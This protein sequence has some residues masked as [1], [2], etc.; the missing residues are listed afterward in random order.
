MIDLTGYENYKEI[1]DAFLL[2]SSV[3]RG[4]GNTAPVAELLMDYAKQNG[5]YAKRDKHDNVIYVKPATPGYE[6]R[7]TVILQGHT[8]MVAQK[9]PDCTKD[10]EKEGIEVVR[11]GESLIANG[12][13]LGGDD[14]VAIAYI[15]ALFK[16]NDIPHPRIEAIMTSDEEIGLLGA[17]GIGEDLLSE[18][19]GKLLI[20]VDS[21]EEGIFTAG[22]AGGMRSDISLPVVREAYEGECYTVAVK[23]LEG[24]HS[25]IE[26]DKGRL[27][28]SKLLADM[29][30]NIDGVRLVEL[31]GGSAD[32]A[33]PR[34]AVAKILVKGN[35]K[36]KILSLYEKI[37]KENET[38][39]P[40][41]TVTVEKSE[42]N[43]TPLNE[44]YSRRVIELICELPSGVISYFQ[45][46]PELVKTSLNLGIMTL[47]YDKLSL[48]FS[49]RS[50]IGE[51]KR[52]LGDR[53]SEI[54]KKYGAGYSERGGYPAWE[55]RESSYLRDT[56]L[57]LYK[58]TYGKDAEVVV[59]HAGLECGLLSDKIEGLDCVS[60]GPDNKY[61]HTTEERLSIPSFV[62]VWDYLKALLKEI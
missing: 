39:E 44:L 40:N 18:L 11:D 23:G 60:I 52:A 59:I 46:I 4:S 25:G 2:L 21:D 42:C 38:N 16:S 54:S 3:P 19:C 55:Y 61:I 51:E 5:I 45:D 28:A 48:S 33:I 56:M 31:N 36:D 43:A 47:E 20:N 24:G 62:R 49:V 53:L 22:C 29:L 17:D 34:E 58:D 6:D 57:K 30:V 12:T 10:M 14:G 9:K 27:N 35:P 1:F 15:M 37:K 26:I 13:T 50:G 7:P 32:N 8:D 41:L